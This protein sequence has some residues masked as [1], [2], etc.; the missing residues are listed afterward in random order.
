MS[1]C[2]VYE[3]HPE[4]RQDMTAPEGNVQKRK[5]HLSLVSGRKDLSVLKANRQET[6]DRSM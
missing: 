6:V 5:I 2:H 4:G 1:N 3:V